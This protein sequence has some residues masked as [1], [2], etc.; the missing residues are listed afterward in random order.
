MKK[1]SFVIMIACFVA[2]YACKNAGSVSNNNDME[3]N[4]EVGL[5]EAS[6]HETAPDNH[7]AEQPVSEALVRIITDHG[8]MTVKLYNE[9]PQHRDNFL[10]LAKEGFYDSLL[11]HR[12]IRNF[13]IQGGDPDSKNARQ[14][15]PLGQGGPGYTIPAEIVPGL[16]HKKGALAAA[17]LGDAMNPTKASSGSQFYL[18]QGR[19]Y[20]EQE[21]NMFEQQ[22][23]RF[24][25][26]QRAAYTTVGG[27]PHLDNEYTVF[28]EVIE[29]LEVIDA[30][31]AV[32]TAPGDRPVKDVR[33]KME[34]IQTH[35]DK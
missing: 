22:G 25:P 32:Q 10:K 11:F 19:A 8:N 15:Q 16:I 28:G 17:R 3:N 23:H 21:I 5:A 33:M 18:V 2:L 20:S 31:A 7:K 26:E 4:G 29:G 24:T 12:V 35:L 14:G 9:T 34:V 6:D 30:I 1:V 13:M 27:T